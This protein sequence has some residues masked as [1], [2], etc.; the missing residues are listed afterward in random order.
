[1]A[2]VTIT[3]DDMKLNVVITF[4]SLVAVLLSNDAALLGPEDFDAATIRAKA[5]FPGGPVELAVYLRD[6][7]KQANVPIFGDNVS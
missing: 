2:N 5:Y 6:L 4:A 7:A 1:M 3:T